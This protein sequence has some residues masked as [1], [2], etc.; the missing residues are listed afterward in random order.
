MYLSPLSSIS[1][2]RYF[3][4][5]QNS[6]ASQPVS[7][8]L[9]NDDSEEPPHSFT[10]VPHPP[11]S[12]HEREQSLLDTPPPH[13]FTIPFPV[14][15]GITSQTHTSSTP[16]QDA[17]LRWGAQLEKLFP[18]D[19]IVIGDTL[20]NISSLQKVSEIRYCNNNIHLASVHLAAAVF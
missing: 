6:M 16:L 18:W 15:L 3:L 17:P 5:A 1:L 19:K 8:F 7:H 9:T 13:L 10:T 14:R 11:S 12:I 20:Q 2:G 4:H